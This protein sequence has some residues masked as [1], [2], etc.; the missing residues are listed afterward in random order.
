M[1][2]WLLV[3]H[4][5]GFSLWI[6][7][8]LVTTILLGRHLR[9]TSPEAKQALASVERVVL[10]AFTDPG[11][12]LTIVAGLALVSTNAHYYLGAT[13]LRIKFGFVVILILLHVVTAMRAKAVAAG[14]GSADPGQSR[15]LLILILLVF[16]SILIVTL[17]GAVYLT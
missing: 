13:W 9:E 4:V 8:L 3:A 5:L 14:R 2:A 16:L 6:S 17:P 1:V 10:R 12:L 15:T 11:A 7:G